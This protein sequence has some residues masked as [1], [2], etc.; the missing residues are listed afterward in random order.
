MWHWLCTVGDTHLYRPHQYSANFN[1]DMGIA[2]K[3]WYKGTPGQPEL[4]NTSTTFSF[5]IL[6]DQILN[7]FL[8]L[9]VKSLIYF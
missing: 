4:V 3:F 8:K 5:E 1:S 9:T 6:N 2:G 7:K